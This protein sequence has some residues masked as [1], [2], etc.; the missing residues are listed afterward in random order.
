MYTVYMV[1]AVLFT[2]TLV[3]LAVASA[4]QE[5]V[6]AKRGDEFTGHVERTR[7]LV[8]GVSSVLALTLLVF[9]YHELY[10]SAVVNVAFI[11]V[12]Y[13]IQV[14]VQARAV[15][16]WRA[17]YHYLQN[18]DTS[19]ED[20]CEGAV[21]YAITYPVMALSPPKEVHKYLNGGSG[22]SPELARYLDAFDRFAW[23]SEHDAR[24][25]TLRLEL[26]AD[27]VS[28]LA[29][30]VYNVARYPEQERNLAE[31]LEVLSKTLLLTGNLDYIEYLQ[32]AEVTEDVED[33]DD[34]L[35]TLSGNQ[36]V[37]QRVRALALL[38][39]AYYQFL[40]ARDEEGIE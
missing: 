25:W 10:L 31:P 11:V 3:A 24:D 16:Q 9:A 5:R 27:A 7:R 12:L 30:V 40:K 21:R 33:F 36:R 1:L 14:V 2:A 19:E 8:L 18:L 34:L 35:E 37:R 4:L 29:S 15:R 22:E 13:T 20:R 17:Y 28:A 38:D 23:E 32:A 26:V 39:D 6:L